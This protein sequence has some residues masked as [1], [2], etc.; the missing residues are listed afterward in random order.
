MRCGRWGTGFGAVLQLVEIK[1]SNAA[2][3]IVAKKL[4]KSHPNSWAK[5]YQTSMIFSVVSPRVDFFFRRINFVFPESR[6]E[7]ILF[8]TGPSAAGQVLPKTRD[9]PHMVDQGV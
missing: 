4:K 1:L 6:A 9:D 7:S 5:T 3:G 8:P 2:L